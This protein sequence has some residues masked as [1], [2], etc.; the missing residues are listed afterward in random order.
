MRK[1]R[2]WLSV[3]ASIVALLAGTGC[4]I[5]PVT[6][7]RQLAIVS[8]EDEVA[9]GTQQY[10]PA[11]Q[12]QG[13]EYVRDAALTRYVRDVGNRLAAVSDRALPYEFVV[14]NSSVP[15]AWALPGGK[16]AVN[17]GLLVELQSEAELAAVL[18]H[19]IV[20]AAARHGAQ[21]MQRGILLQG[22]VLIA[23]AATRDRDYSGVAVGA[24]GLGAQLINMRNGREAELEADAYGMRYMSRAGYDPRA[25]IELQQTFVRLSQARDNG[26]WLAGLFASHPPSA[27]RVA[28]NQATAATLPPTGTL[29][30]EAYQNATTNLRRDVPGYEALDAASQALRAGDLSLARREANTALDRLRDE[31]QAEAILGDIEMAAEQPSRALG[32]YEQ[33]LRLNDGFFYYHL[34][35]ADAHFTLGQMNDAETAYRAS[36]TLL[37]TADAHLGLGRIAERRGDRAT[38]VDQYGRAA[39]SSGASGVEARRALV[40]LDLPENPQRYLT[41]ANTLDNAGRLV[42]RIENGTEF[43]V[44]SIQLVVS[45]VG[46]DGRASVARRL[47][48]GTLAAG[49]TRTHATSLGPFAPG[50]AYDVSIESVRVIEP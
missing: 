2:T 14:I 42:V 18:G 44:G 3:T 37:P 48:D 7:Q 19:E 25:A 29:G 40:R 31:A 5:N 34:A 47:L 43:E 21:A 32:H 12:M 36:L 13:G 11:Q 27:E 45:Y 9:I 41:L 20:H 10:Q 24:A 39:E 38:A 49:A 28:A 17:R 23:S 35:K 33:A 22:A 16:I 4:T 26:G 15:N 50:T 30:R 8:A 6:G 1:A 46:S